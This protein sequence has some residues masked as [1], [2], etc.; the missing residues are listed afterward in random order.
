MKKYINY[1]SENFN[2]QGLYPYN[3]NPIPQEE[4]DRYGH[5]SIRRPANFGI[6][7]QDDGVYLLIRLSRDG[8]NNIIPGYYRRLD[9]SLSFSDEELAEIAYNADMTIAHS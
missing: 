6:I 1:S 4:L 3:G 9:D 5:G 7:R 8:S 2:I